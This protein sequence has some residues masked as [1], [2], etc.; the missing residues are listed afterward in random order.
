MFLEKS[1]EGVYQFKISSVSFTGSGH[2]EVNGCKNP[3]CQCHNVNLKLF[4]DTQ[5]LGDVSVDVFEE[6][7]QPLSENAKNSSASNLADIL[8]TLFE[9]EDWTSLRE[10]FLRIKR[11]A[12]ENIDFE[13]SV[14]PF[15]MAKDIE[16]Y[17]EMVP[18]A[19]VLPFSE[20]FWL[21]E[22][23]EAIL[24]D[25]Q[26]CLQSDCDC[27]RALIAFIHFKG[28]QQAE[29]EPPL[30]FIDYDSE[31]MEI[32][33]KG[34][35][36]QDVGL[37]IKKVK[38]H[39]PEIIKKIRERHTV[40]KALYRNFKLSQRPKPAKL[41]TSKVGRNDPCICGSGKKFKK[42]CAQVYS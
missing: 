12:T 42:C 21:I 36:A 3:T 41:A 31:K 9:K 26:Y 24:V 4:T 34:T 28:N 20:I 27:T 37:L 1:N 35:P 30:V 7:F 23:D 29:G 40:L 16:K 15:P 6:K 10:D 17:S 5:S 39:Y 38:Q 11:Q 14:I 19:S 25:D 2:I 22:G 8:A 13:N 33:S 32:S 18:F